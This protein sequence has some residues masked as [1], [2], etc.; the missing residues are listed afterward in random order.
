MRLDPTNRLAGAV[1]ALQLGSEPRAG[2]DRQPG[3]ETESDARSV[4]E[5]GAGVVEWLGI[6]AL[7]V[8]MLIVLFDALEQIG[9]RLIE[10][11]GAQLGL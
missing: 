7:S 2:R 8:A 9:L 5:R 11:I 3:K 4:S 1:P 10:A 6:S